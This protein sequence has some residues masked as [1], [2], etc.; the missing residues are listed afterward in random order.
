MKT[1]PEMIKE[2][3]RRNLKNLIIFWIAGAIIIFVGF[4]IILSSS[5]SSIKIFSD[6]KVFLQILA[7]AIVV[8]PVIWIIGK[9]KI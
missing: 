2:T 7:I 8:P 5:D 4:A 3:I 6:V 1:V 9:L